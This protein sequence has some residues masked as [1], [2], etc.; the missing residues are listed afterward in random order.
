MSSNKDISI[1]VSDVTKLFSIYDKP[2][3]RL[4]N[5]LFGREQSKKE[6]F[7]ALKNVSFSIKKGQTV[8]ILGKNG[9]GKSTLLQIICKTL[10]AESGRVDVTGRIAALLELGTGFNP[11]F[12]GRENVYLNARVL[13]LGK[14][15]IESRFDDI[16]AFAEIGDFIDRPMKTYSTGMFVRL[17]FAVAINVSPDILIIDEALAVGDARFQAK[18]FDKIREIKEGGA[19]ILFVTHDVGSIRQLCDNA[20][21]LDG[22]EVRMIGDVLGVTSKYMEFMFQDEETDAASSN[23]KSLTAADLS[24]DRVLEEIDPLEIEGIDTTKPI[25]HWGDCLGCVQ[26]CHMFG[27]N[28]QRK[29]V[30]NDNELIEIKLRVKLPQGISY[31][32]FGIGFALRTLNGTDLVVYD[33]HGQGLEFN[34]DNSSCEILF[35]LDNPLNEGKYLLVVAVEDRS[36]TQPS[37]YE[38][39]EGVEYFSVLRTEK[40]FGLFVPKVACNIRYL[41]GAE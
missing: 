27:E 1:K 13:G 4:T 26:F 5:I 33:T 2:V 14:R 35:S 23:M 40:H 34:A 11:D 38:F 28:G 17:A 19:T 12:T 18:C 15:E 25:N 31:D 9:S 29:Q 7:V 32:S 10:T 3:D 37:Y 41:E 39:I 21:W 24:C 20:I 6:Q 8:G 16:L 30:F 36:K 22:G